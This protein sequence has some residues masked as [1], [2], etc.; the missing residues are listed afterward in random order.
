MSP[1]PRNSP[2]IEQN[3]FDRHRNVP[4]VVLVQSK[5]S[6]VDSWQVIQAPCSFLSF[7]KGDI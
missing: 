4:V 7:L 6:E 2:I 5:G 1:E 3:S